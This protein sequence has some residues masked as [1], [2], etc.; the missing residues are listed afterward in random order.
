MKTERVRV[1]DVLSLQR[2]SVAVVPD[3]EYTLVGCYSFGKG[4]FHREPRLGADLGAFRYFEI[5]PG[6]L[7]LSN[8]QAWEGA[9]AFASAVD[10]GTVG[11]HRFLTYTARVPTVDLN[12]VRWFLLSE[13]GMDLIRLAAPG[14]T[15]RNRTLAIDRFENLE[16]PLPPIEEQR[17][18]AARIN[19]VREVSGRTTELRAASQQL[20]IALGVSVCSRPDLSE[21]LKR[22]ARWR[23]VSLGDV[24][25]P[26][27]TPTKVEAGVSY[28]NFGIYSFGRGV[29][30]K[31]DVD[32]SA[33][34]ASWLNRVR[35]GQVIYSRL[36]AFEG[37]Y[38]Y[39]PQR[40]DGHYVSNEFP[41]F[42]PDPEALN[43]RWLAAYL[44]NSTHWAALAGSSKGLGVRR[45]RVPVSALLDYRVWLP[46]IEVQ[47]SMVATIERL[48]TVGR[49]AGVDPRIAALLP[50]ALSEAFADLN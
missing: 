5:R 18:V 4:L 23:R 49:D 10:A 15:M 19:H 43:A 2:R 21:D 14:T 13:P 27:A 3:H 36:F 32:G 29:F 25:E 35:A 39:V 11:T 16:I 12:W 22:T 24:M 34:S 28:P 38:A 45:Q 26:A 46:P 8:I 30:P 44:R 33:T 20:A 1:G 40:F 37:A 7:V 47:R 6:D 42:D 9:I 48:P 41:T 31:P 17:R 50:S